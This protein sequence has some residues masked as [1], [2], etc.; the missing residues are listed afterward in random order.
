MT[1]E[2]PRGAQRRALTNSYLRS[3]PGTTLSLR[4]KHQTPQLRDHS[5]RTSF[6]ASGSWYTEG[7]ESCTGVDVPP[8]LQTL[9]GLK[10]LPFSV[11][12]EEEEAEADDTDRAPSDGGIPLS[13]ETTPADSSSIKPPHRISSA[14]EVKAEIS[15]VQR[16]CPERAPTLETEELKQMLLESKTKKKRRGRRIKAAACSVLSRI[17]AS[18]RAL[19]KKSVSS[20]ARS[21]V[22]DTSTSQHGFHALSP[23]SDA[24]TEANSVTPVNSD[25]LKT[26]HVQQLIEQQQNQIKKTQE[27]IEELQQALKASIEKYQS[28]L[29]NLQHAQ[30]Q[31]QRLAAETLSHASPP[32]LETFPDGDVTELNRNPRTLKRSESASFMRVS[33]LDLANAAAAATQETDYEASVSSLSHSAHSNRSPQMAVA[34]DDKIPEF[35]LMDHY[36]L[37]I[38][39][40]LIQ[41]AY[42]LVT[43]EGDRFAPTNDTEKLIAQKPVSVHVDQS[44][45]IHP[46]EATWGSHV[47]VWTGSVPHE[48]FGSSWPVVKGRGILH[49][50]AKKVLEY[51]WDS[52]EVPKYNPM[53]Q[54]RTDIYVLQDN[55]DTT[56]QESPYG[57]IGC[58]KIVQSLNKHRLLPKAVEMKSFLYARPLAEHKGSYILVSRSVWENNTATL[59]SQPKNV[60]RSEMLLGGTLLRAIDDETCEMT[61][62]THAYSPG[63]PEMLVRR[64]AP[65]QCSNLMKALQA[66]FPA[67]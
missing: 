55:V 66:Q 21:L 14:T 61:Q 34:V 26:K 3:E 65:G 10:F 2:G 9:F 36:L 51:L 33:D 47:L 45:P 12:V 13:V 52:E 6:T 67:R 11:I 15:S 4:T 49:A 62:L 27:E 7:R 46:W 54:G 44:W 57:L 30:E 22:V 16:Q 8:L 43:D 41:K 24:P 18:R 5:S 48:G 53:S 58:A 32:K 31:L 64:T 50:S 42:A 56:A 1:E 29:A 38:V 35:L 20:S 37:E 63:V 28:Q 60:I 39:Q 19:S 25:T 23:I 17:G 59:E 40:Q